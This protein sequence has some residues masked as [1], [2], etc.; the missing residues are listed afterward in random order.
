[1]TSTSKYDARINDQKKKVD[2]AVAELRKLKNMQKAEE[3]KEQA[4]RAGKR[5]IVLET[6]LPDTAKLD[7]SHFKRF[8]EMT[9][10]N[11]FGKNKLKLIL[12]EQAKPNITE[13][14]PVPAQSK[15][16][17]QIKPAAMSQL[18]ETDSEDYEDF[19]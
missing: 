2:Q 7:D 10:T 14:V 9:I 15:N 13:S 16:T 17:A 1:M 3:R 8:L 11:D 19:I 18:D 12:N 5:G 4:E 6:L